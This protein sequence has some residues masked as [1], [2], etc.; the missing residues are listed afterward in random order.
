P[1]LGQGAN[2][3]LLDAFALSAALSAHAERADALAAYA[4][5]RRWHVRLYQAASYLFTP[6]YQSDGVVLPF[7]RDRIVG[8]LSQV[9]PAP[10]ILAALVA[11]AIGAPLRA[12]RG[13]RAPAMIPSLHVPS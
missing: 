11:G 5:M 6:V 13:V 2:M 3:A 9:P 8:P 1:Q 10:Q 4:R 12:I 7:L